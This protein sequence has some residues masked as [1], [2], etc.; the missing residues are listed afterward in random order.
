M[1]IRELR[2][3][4]TEVDNQEMTVKQLRDILFEVEEQDEELTGFDLFKMTRDK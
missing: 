4:L 2:S 1:T 3:M